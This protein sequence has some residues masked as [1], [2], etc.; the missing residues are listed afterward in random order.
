VLAEIPKRCNRTS[1]AA[2]FMLIGA[3][4]RRSSPDSGGLNDGEVLMVEANDNVSEFSEDLF[5]QRRSAQISGQGVLA[6]MYR[7]HRCDK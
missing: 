2:M 5:I 4:S 7:F 3:G 1:P 6:C